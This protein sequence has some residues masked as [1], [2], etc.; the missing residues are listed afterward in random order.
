MDRA[1]GVNKVTIIIRDPTTIGGISHRRDGDMPITIAIGS[2]P[3][4]GNP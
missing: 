4:I 3:G 2:A 1:P